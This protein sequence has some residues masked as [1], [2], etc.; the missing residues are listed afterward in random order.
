LE[1]I[2]VR[3]QRR[4]GMKLVFGAVGLGN[5][6]LISRPLILSRPLLAIDL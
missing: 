3:R 1:I 2:V 5:R 4:N 6:E